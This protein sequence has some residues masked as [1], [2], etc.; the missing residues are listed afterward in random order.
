MKILLSNGKVFV[1]DGM[2]G[3]CEYI[4]DPPRLF[5]NMAKAAQKSGRG[6]IFIE[7]SERVPFG[8]KNESSLEPISSMG[9]IEILANME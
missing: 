4:P 7:F 2:M 6:D 1:S 8:G 9:L 5:L 3:K